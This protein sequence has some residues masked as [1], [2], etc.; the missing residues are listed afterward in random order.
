MKEDM[1]LDSSLDAIKRALDMC[2]PDPEDLIVV[3]PGRQRTPEEEDE[4]YETKRLEMELRA[5]A[6]ALARYRAA[7][8]WASS[9]PLDDWDADD[10][11]CFASWADAA[12][13]ASLR[14]RIKLA[15]RI[16][17]RKLVSPGLS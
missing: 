6:E 10:E 11:A 17:L 3:I 5:D 9:R 4:W 2:E 14:K 7:V 16:L 13:K 1:V 15:W 8:E 12:C